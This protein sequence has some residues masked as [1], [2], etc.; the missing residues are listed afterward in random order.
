[1]VLRRVLMVGVG[2]VLV[3][4]CSDGGGSGSPALDAIAAE[5]ERQAAAPLCAEVYAEGEVTTAEHV[6]S[7]CMDGG[8]LHVGGVSVELCV[9]GRTLVWSD[10][11]WGFVGEPWTRVADS[12]PPEDVLEVCA[13]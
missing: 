10:W 13:P 2:V 7:G 9:D 12:G 5:R 8:S 1:M 4:G 3:G 11:G 6:E